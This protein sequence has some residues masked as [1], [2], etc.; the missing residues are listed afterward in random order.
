VSESL[1]GLSRTA[2]LAAQLIAQPSVT[3]DDRDCQRIVGERLARMGFRLET[4]RR[5]G[6]TNLWARRGDSRP[7]VCFAGHTDVVPT[8]PREQ[9]LSDPFTPTVRDGVLYGRGASDMKT[10]IAAFVTAVE[11]FL[12]ATPNPAG[13]I[14]FCL[15]SDEEGRAIDGTRL[16]VEMLRERGEAIDYCIIGEPS[17]VDKVGD[18][19]KIGRRGTLSGKV[20]VNGVQGHIAYPH[21]ALNPIHAVAPALSDLTRETW[22]LGNEHFPPTSFQ[23]SNINAGTGAGNVIPGALE[24]LFNFRYSTESTHETL[25]SRF[26]AMMCRHNVP[27]DIEW[28][29]LGLPFLTEQGALVTTMK[30]AIEKVTGIA[31]ALSCTGGTSDG[32][33]IATWCRELVEFGPTNATIHKINESVALNE[34]EPLREVYLQA[35]KSLLSENKS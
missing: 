10:S 18:M 11:D 20:R 19:I 17:S 34:I 25:K 22:D 4:V 23:V 33:F 12:S 24:M 30:R 27:C 35:L 9:W 5:N 21:L 31:P 7:L 3:P 26:T 15:T 1:T 6:V 29:G 2:K 32:R 14:A 28:T 8:G 13:S 16:M